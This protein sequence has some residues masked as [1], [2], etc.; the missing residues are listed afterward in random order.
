MCGDHLLMKAVTKLNL[1]SP[2][3]VRG[4]LVSRYA[5]SLYFG[6]TPACA[7]TTCLK[8]L[9]KYRMRDHPRMCGDHRLFSVRKRTMKGSPPH[10]RGPPI[11]ASTDRYN[12]GIT[13]ACAGTTKADK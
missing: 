11:L 9:N 13:P 8:P 10:V 6:I 1:G 2:P 5:R 7:G 4:P 3:H 12:Y